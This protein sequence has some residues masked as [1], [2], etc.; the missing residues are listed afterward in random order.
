M[1]VA[2]ATRSNNRCR[3]YHSRYSVKYK[4]I[5]R[6]SKPAGH[7]WIILNMLPQIRIDPILTYYDVY[8]NTQEIVSS[9]T[10]RIKVEWEQ[11]RTVDDIVVPSILAMYLSLGRYEHSGD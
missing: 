3:A 10:R 8:R 4:T 2:R 11:F 7:D 6:S 1:D 9:H 5:F